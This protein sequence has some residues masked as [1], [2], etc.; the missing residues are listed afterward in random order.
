MLINNYNTPVSS[1]K[2]KTNKQKK[3]KTQNIIKHPPTHST[4]IKRQT[5]ENTEMKTQKKNKTHT[6]TTN[7][8]T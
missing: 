1:Q 6:W 2:K 5:T 3:Y 4:R 7:T 8:Q